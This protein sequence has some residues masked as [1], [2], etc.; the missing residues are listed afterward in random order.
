MLPIAK[1]RSIN[2]KSG[3]GVVEFGL[4]Q[5][6]QHLFLVPNDGSAF[7]PSVAPCTYTVH[8]IANNTDT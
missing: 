3:S 8:T 6:V 2:S 5:A 4:Q 1:S 7:K